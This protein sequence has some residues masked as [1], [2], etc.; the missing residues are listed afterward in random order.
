MA[1]SRAALRFRPRLTIAGD[2]R[3]ARR[4]VSSHSRSSSR[5]ARTYRLGFAGFDTA[6]TIS[7]R[8]LIAVTLCAALVGLAPFPAAASGRPAPIVLDS[9]SPCGPALD[10]ALGVECVPA[11]AS[12]YGGWSAWTRYAR[13]PGQFEL[14]VRSPAG[15]VSV[16]PIAPRYSPFDVELGPAGSHVLAVYSRCAHTVS[17][18]GCT[19][20]ELPLGRPGDAERRLDVPLRGSLHE[21]AIWNGTLVFLRRNGRGNEDPFAPQ[22]VRPDGLFEWRIGTRHVSSLALPRSRGVDR[23]QTATYWP[24]GLTGVVSGLTLRG[25]DVAYTT[26]VASG[27]F[28]MSTLW[29]ESLGG[30]PRLVDQLAAGQG[31][32][33]APMILSPVITGPW[34]YAY[35]HACTAGGGPISAD[36]FTRYSLASSAA[37]R[38]AFNFIHHIDDAIESVE[39]DGRGVIWDNGRVELLRS[40]SWVPIARP[41]P[42]TFCTRADAFC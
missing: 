15:V 12:S 11:T 26:A 33:C 2:P 18:R 5:S 41:V 13:V 19:I 22:G 10:P 21:P 30:R 23:P 37:E 8:L 7:R 39:P 35:V 9:S 14:V 3:A 4:W 31:N 25:S 1:S 38:A 20:D 32:V 36:R 16:P 17:D 34:L 6:P 24:R 40:I 29:Q 42:A 28:A 27:P